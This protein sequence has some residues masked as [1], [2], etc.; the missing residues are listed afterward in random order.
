MKDHC[1]HEKR[2]RN[3]TPNLPLISDIDASASTCPKQVRRFGFRQG[4]NLE[5]NEIES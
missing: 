2:I 3:E 1:S 5:R 4:E